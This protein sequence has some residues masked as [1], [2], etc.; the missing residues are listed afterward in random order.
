MSAQVNSFGR[1][2]PTSQ[3][4]IIP[5][6]KPKHDKNSDKTSDKTSDKNGRNSPNKFV[7][8]LYPSKDKNNKTNHKHNHI[9]PILTMKELEN[10]Q[11]RSISVSPT[12]NEPLSISP[13][14]NGHLSISP[15][16]NSP[17]KFRNRSFR[18][19]SNSPPTISPSY[20]IKPIVHSKEINVKEINA[21]EINA[22]EINEI[23]AKEIN[24][25]N[26]ININ[27]IDDINKG[28]MNEK[29][30]SNTN[31]V[32]NIQRVPHINQT[33]KVFNKFEYYTQSQLIHFIKHLVYQHSALICGAFNT[34]QLTIS[35]HTNSFMYQIK[36]YQQ[37]NSINLTESQ[38]NDFF[39]NE[40]VLPENKQRLNL[41]SSMDIL[42]SHS[43]FINFIINL[44]TYFNTP[45]KQN[46]K[47]EYI[48]KGILKYNNE[49]TNNIE[50]YNTI[51]NKIYLHVVKF[52][53]ETYNISFEINFIILHND[54]TILDKSYIIPLIIP[55]GLYDTENLYITNN[56]VNEIYMQ[57]SSSS[58]TYIINNI[59]MNIVSIMPK[60]ND[61]DYTKLAL[62]IL[63]IM[64]VSSNTSYLFEF[65]IFNT[66]HKK[67]DFWLTNKKSENK[68]LDTDVNDANNAN[69]ALTCT[70][71]TINISTNSKYVIAKCCHK[72]YHIECMEMNY[73]VRD[74]YMYLVCDCG[75]AI[76]DENSCNDKLLHAL[77][78]H[79][80]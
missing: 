28:D 18:S 36:N 29:S 24:E 17:K 73:Y 46:Y 67:S 8:T 80:Y 3:T 44:K 9:K 77:Y 37:I 76:I 70:K 12:S 47:L 26:E 65:D 53:E 48:N 38:I 25:I 35:E 39:I 68:C 63:Q 1:T 19:T 4:P 66:I 64:S 74:Y 43:N 49:D 54:K 5:K 10:N 20:T 14:S 69:N 58:L 30:I 41:Q 55:F 16:S 45:L 31:Q 32:S 42:I 40:L 78:K 27:D 34:H 56:G 52:F 72:E 2:S 23:N 7:F 59:N 57:H 21:K 61:P 50:Y 51:G 60:I 22:K 6:Y 62:Y 13:T 75:C 15:T 71:C 11:D 79:Y 33:V